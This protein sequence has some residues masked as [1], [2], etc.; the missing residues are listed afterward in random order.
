MQAVFISKLIN[1]KKSEEP[2]NMEKSYFKEE[3][4]FSNPWFWAFLIVVFTVSL[5]PIC[6]ALYSELVLGKPFGENP[7]SVESMLIM[8]GVLGIVYFFVILLFR[9][10]KLITEVRGDG[11][12]YRF[13]PFILKNRKFGKAE[14]ERFEIRK[15]KP[16]TEYGGWGIR[17]GWGKWGRALSVWGKTGLQLYLSDGKKVL[18]GTQRPDSLLRAMNKMMKEQ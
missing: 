2:K 1:F 7:S 12:Y 14:I 5:T 10:M 18:F 15:Y 4:H 6:V 13:P 16:I 8:F 17:Y 11:I 9:K 3:Q